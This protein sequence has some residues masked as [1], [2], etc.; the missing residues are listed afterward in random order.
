MFYSEYYDYI[1]ENVEIVLVP[2]HLPPVSKLAESMCSNLRHYIYINFASRGVDVKF[3]R[4][5]RNAMEIASQSEKE[6]TFFIQ[7]GTYI[8]PY[9]TIKGI[10]EMLEY[11]PDIGIA[12]HILDRKE[13]YYEIHSQNFVIHNDIV[14][15]VGEYL[16]QSTEPL[17]A[18]NVMRS[19][20]NYHDDYTPL[21]IS[22]DEGSK[23]IDR[24][25]NGSRL[26]NYALRSGYTVQPYSKE[27]RDSKDFLYAYGKGFYRNYPRLLKKFDV[28]G[29]FNIFNSTEFSADNPKLKLDHLFVTAGGIDSIRLAYHYRMG[30]NN[31]ITIYDYS[32]EALQ[33]QKYLHD[34]QQIDFDNY[35]TF[36]YDFLETLPKHLSQKVWDYGYLQKYILVELEYT[37]TDDFKEWYEN[38][39]P[40]ITKRYMK[41]DIF[42]SDDFDKFLLGGNKT[43]VIHISNIHGYIANSLH[44]DADFKRQVFKDLLV[45]LSS[46]GSDYYMNDFMSPGT[47]KHIKELDPSKLL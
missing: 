40:K 22:V 21:W 5:W 10:Y 20:Q 27:V 46:D 28:K 12:G 4:N 11:I 33:Y 43:S 39:Y 1:R 15:N 37:K 24:I 42:N 34:Y 35:M 32:E 44:Y 17:I 16:P 3:S 45:K 36:M 25:S 13:K 9:K 8:H 23:T 7:E 38:E 2:L 18:K 19:E 26:I 14:R 41:L 6:F 30:E 47:V 31:A 29:T